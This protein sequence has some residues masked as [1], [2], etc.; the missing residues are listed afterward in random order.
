MQAIAVGAM[1]L[2]GR[3]SQRRPSAILPASPLVGQKQIAR[4][5]LIP[6]WTMYHSC[7]G[8]IT[9]LPAVFPAGGNEARVR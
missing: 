2:S 3:K 1:W 7:S 5:P 8:L 9:C 4:N 6:E